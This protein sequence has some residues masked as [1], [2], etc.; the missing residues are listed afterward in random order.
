MAAKGAL[1]R[2][3]L[4][5]VLKS[6]TAHYPENLADKSWDNTGLLI[7]C[8]VPEDNNNTVPTTKPKVLL[9]VDLT[10]AVA[11]EAI[12]H[13]CNLIIAYHPFI[14]PSWKFLDP[15]RNT[16][17][18]SAIQ[19]IQNSISVYSPHTAMD[20]AKGGINDWMALG[21]VKNDFTAI[22]SIVSIEK[23]SSVP[24]DDSIGYGRVVTLN[25]P[26][27][28]AKLIENI[29]ESCGI[30]H[31]QIASP[32][33]DASHYNNVKKIALCAG[34]GSGVFKALNGWDDIDVFYTGEMSHHDL[35]KM[36]EMGKTCIVC[37]HTNTE[38]GYLQDVLADK[39]NNEG[40]DCIVSQVD[41]D[42]LRVV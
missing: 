17:H 30:S 26:L 16:Q 35:L 10:N 6:F 9:T 7:N 22:S 40:I 3:Q 18:R 25:Q 19:L 12:T 28:L 11:K 24:G 34:S 39:L 20:A 1:T 29:K 33:G 37:N 41:Q 31:L 5:Q 38:R 4:N 27:N 13:G 2:T 21:L 23:C 14:F 42:P 36:K 32:F 8:S 15:D